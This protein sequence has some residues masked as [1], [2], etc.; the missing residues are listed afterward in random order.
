M[1]TGQNIMITGGT[2][3]FGQKMVQT[4]LDHFKPNRIVI[5]SRDEYKQSLMK[6]KFPPHIYKHMRYFIGDV[7]DYDRLETAFHDIDIV[8]HASAM[9]RIQ[10]CEY[11][12]MEAIKTNILGTN[13]VVRAAIKNKI[14]Y[15]IG[16]STD[17]ACSPVN[18]Y[19][20]CKLIGEKLLLNGNILS[21]GTTKFAVCR[22]GNIMASRGSLFEIFKKQLA[23]GKQVTVTDPTMTR[24][25][26]LQQE[27]VNFVL[28]CLTMM[29]GGEIFIPKL[30]SYSVKQVLEC[31]HIKEYE[32]LGPRAGE[33]FHELM[34]SCDE[35]DLTYEFNKFFVLA[36]LTEWNLQNFNIEENHLK[37]LYK[38]EQYKKRGFNNPYSS[39][40]AP[41]ISNAVLIELM[42]SL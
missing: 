13:N 24:F 33:K 18:T 17:K 32:V 36:P 12:P 26:M 42:N 28:F 29:I 40:D 21:S 6:E 38:G 25:N 23:E 27:A 1:L 9:K 31:F 39:K 8:F 19:G 10:E 4:L 22:Y 34:I 37:G 16:L 11:D 20:A 14:K 2:G 7:R 5:Y 30:P 41:Q 15:V 35:S 3:S